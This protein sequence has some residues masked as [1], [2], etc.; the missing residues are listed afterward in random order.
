MSAEPRRTISSRIFGSSKKLVVRDVDEPPPPGSPN[1]SPQRK[2]G[3]GFKVLNKAM[4]TATTKQH[5]APEVTMRS[6]GAS[7]KMRSRSSLDMD[8]DS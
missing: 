4:V 7:P 2:R 1:A 5:G 3:G 8:A 6:H